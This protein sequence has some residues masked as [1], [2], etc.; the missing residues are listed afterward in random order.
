MKK[1]KTL[2]HKKTKKRMRETRI[3]RSVSL[4]AEQDQKLRAA[5]ADGDI[6]IVVRE[7][8]DR[9]LTADGAKKYLDARDKGIQ[10]AEDIERLLVEAGLE[11]IRDAKING[12]ESHRTDILCSHRGKRCCI[13]LKSDSSLGRLELAL[14]LAMVLKNQSGLPAIVCVPYVTD[15]KIPGLFRSLNVGLATPTNVVEVVRGFLEPGKQ[16]NR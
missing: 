10:F 9:G 14:G 5:A 13:E 11:V 6:S 4:Y 3:T 2:V 15:E 12:D 8:I 7:L 1:P 16:P